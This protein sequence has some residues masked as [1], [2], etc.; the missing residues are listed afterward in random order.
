[1]AIVWYTMTT[2]RYTVLYISNAEE[3]NMNKCVVY[4][5]DAYIAKIY[6]AN[7][8]IYTEKLAKMIGLA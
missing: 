2:Y 7:I 4:V 6:L 1:M 5:C 8:L 3:G